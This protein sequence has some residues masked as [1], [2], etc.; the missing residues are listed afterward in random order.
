MWKYAKTLPMYWYNFIQRY[1]IYISWFSSILITYIHE[2]IIWSIH[3]LESCFCGGKLKR[4]PRKDDAG[5]L[6]QPLLQRFGVAICGHNGDLLFH[7][8]GPI[9]GCN[10]TVLEVELTVLKRGLTQAVSL[11]ITHISLYCDYHPLYELVSFNSLVFLIKAY[12][13]ILWSC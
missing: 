10:V 8:K 5:K 2:W 1:F 11:G 4:F 12:V 6:V 7:L 9:H 13:I 3:T